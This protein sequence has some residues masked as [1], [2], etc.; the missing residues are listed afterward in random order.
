MGHKLQSI[1]SDQIHG[2]KPSPSDFWLTKVFGAFGFLG[3]VLG[4]MAIAMFTPGTR[5]D[6]AAIKGGFFVQVIG[7]CGLL[8]AQSHTSTLLPLFIRHSQL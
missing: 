6:T 5:G 8:A 7:L 3:F 2:S 4:C 1:E